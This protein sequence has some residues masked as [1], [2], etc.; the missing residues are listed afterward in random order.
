MSDFD[1]ACQ[2]RYT[3][4]MQTER[5]TLENG[6]TLLLTPMADASSV[7]LLCAVPVGSRHETPAEAGLAHFFEHMAFKGGKKYRNA[8]AVFEALDQYGAQSNAFTDTEVTA[9]YVKIAPKHLDVAIDVLAD[10]L[11]EARFPQAEMEKEKGVVI[12]EHKMYWDM[13]DARADMQFGPLLF[14]RAAVGRPVI[15]EPATIKRFTGD[16]LRRW[17]RHYGA[18]RFMIS[19]AGNL[20]HGLAKR[21]TSAFAGLP[22][23]AVLPTDPVS[24]WTDG[25]KWL[26]DERPGEQ[27]QLVMGWPG[28]ANRDDR[29]WAMRLLRTILGGYASSR[30]FTEVR[31]RR[32]LCYTIRAVDQ[33]YADTGILGITAGLDANRLTEAFS[34][35][36]GEVEK[37]A[38]K[39]VPPA[40]LDRAREYLKGS[41]A[42]GLEGTYS[43]AWWRADQ[44]L[45]EGELYDLPHLY[46]H[47]DAVSAAD[48]QKLAKELMV[49]AHLGVVLVGPPVK[50]DLLKQIVH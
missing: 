38:S 13:P 45:S 22:K 20:P 36:W 34:A 7:T 46:R 50:L 40:E 10:M 3:P 16:D 2:G 44:W 29:R 24:P 48:I 31:E 27:T 17:R 43:V 26:T 39:P 9:Y 15:G 5:T 19:A 41:A 23:T 8:R 1:G 49:T 28:I 6:S 47:L 18:S 35:I 37:M 33:G 32:G 42:I 21:L 14:G 11:T 12:E 4:I 30:L 25:P